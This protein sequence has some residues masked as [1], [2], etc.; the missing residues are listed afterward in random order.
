[1]DSLGGMRPLHGM[2]REEYGAV[3]RH[4]TAGG[5]QVRRAEGR[6]VAIMAAHSSRNAAPATST[7]HFCWAR[8]R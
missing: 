3:V 6:S 8:P 2:T 5:S 1:M 7:S 4:L